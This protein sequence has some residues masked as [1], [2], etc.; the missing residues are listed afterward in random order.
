MIPRSL[1]IKGLYSYQDH[2]INTVNF[3]RLVEGRLFG[4]FGPVGAGK[5]ALLEAITYALYGH[6]ERLN[7]QERRGYNMM[8]LRSKRLEII[9]EFES[10][11]RI[12]KFE[13]KGRRNSKNFDDST[14]KRQGYRWEPTKEGEGEWKPLES[15]DAS[16]I[17]GLS[18]EHFTKTVIIPQGR[19]QE[20]LH[21]S[22]TERTR[23]LQDL[24]ALERFDLAGPTKR[25][26]DENDHAMA[27]LE[28]QLKELPEVKEEEVEEKENE[29]G[30]MEAELEAAREEEGKMKKE[31]ENWGKIKDLRDSLV[32]VREILAPLLEDEAEFQRQQKELQRYQLLKA[33]FQEPLQRKARLEELQEKLRGEKLGLEKGREEKAVELEKAEGELAEAKR[34]YENRDKWRL[35]AEDL[36]KVAE[37]YE[38]EKEVGE[39]EGRMKNGKEKIGEAEGDL[40][41]LL[42]EMEGKESEEKRLQSEQMDLARLLEIQAWLREYNT[43][44]T[45]L[46]AIRETL[47]SQQAL[48]EIH[49][50]G[51]VKWASEVNAK[52]SDDIFPPFGS[53]SIP[54]KAQNPTG[55]SSLFDQPAAQA[56]TLPDLQAALQ[57]AIGKQRLSVQSRSQVLETARRQSGLAA[58]AA[59][60]Q[61]GEACPLCGA[62]DH[63]HPYHDSEQQAQITTLE[64]ELKAEELALEELQDLQPDLIR[65]LEQQ[66]Q[67]AFRSREFATALGQ[68][69][70]HAAAWTSDQAWE[71]EKPADVESQIEAARAQ[72]RNLE[73]L[74]KALSKL[75][76]SEKALRQDLERFQK[77]IEDFRHQKAVLQGKSNTLREQLTQIAPDALPERSPASLRE[78]AETHRQRIASIL[79]RYE[80][81]GKRMEA[82]RLEVQ[83]LDTELKVVASKLQSASADLK[84]NADG[85]EKKLETSGLN[86]IED[87]RRILEKERDVEAETVAIEAYFTQLNESR[88]EFESLEKQLDGRQYDAERHVQVQERLKALA[89]SQ[90]S[91]NQALGSLAEQIKKMKATRK[92]RA[93]LI[94]NQS[95]LFTRRDN[96]KLLKKL[97]DR[98]GFVNYI[99]TIYLRDLCARAN[100]R[101]SSLTQNRLSLEIDT[102]N[103]FVIRDNLNDGRTRSVKTLSGGQT[104]QAA[105]SLALALADNIH[106]RS[107]SQHN[108]FFLDEGF[109]TLD[110]ASLTTVFD[111]LKQLRRENRI[112]GVISHV[113]ELQEEIDLSI[114][115][116]Q[117]ED[118]GSRITA[119]WEK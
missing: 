112:V 83:E 96:L 75:R 101:F 19:F 54:E 92:K 29:R 116:S 36:E 85:I 37:I 72:V 93:E 42:G 15:K 119:S 117:D 118:K 35:A 11:G 51:M 20:F 17:L 108:F 61:A 60:I 111:T 100:R 2:R 67:H 14:L 56:S 76:D 82:L 5:S 86:G 25:L 95:R 46:R 77:A 21:M 47:A 74:R 50:R 3:E 27:A 81:S 89:A 63:P 70:A 30:K 6:T 58:F 57:A 79:R 115:I 24:F 78:E 88:A 16:E 62:T 4:I 38:L 33:S 48:E 91:L 26:A 105:L 106:Q 1:S 39:L 73:A 87:I 45:E 7:K 53:L 18:Y 44:Q 22:T 114:H 68:R 9:F 55:Q 10:G 90:T 64:A 113:E 34:E 32:E 84:E 109:G 43:R 40:Q 8:N 52:R 23:M 94:G 69:E 97:F 59:Q 99:S 107:H 71:K 102:D 28:G 13:V 110:R 80:D 41:K 66:K 12:Y 103:Q 104:F 49:L 65:L 98:S 31:H